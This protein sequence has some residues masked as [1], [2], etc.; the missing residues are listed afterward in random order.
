MRAEFPGWLGGLLAVLVLF[1]F[2]RDLPSTAII[3]LSIP[4]LLYGL[5]GSLRILQ[6]SHQHA[7]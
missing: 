2:L 7:K 3:G 1:F 4:V 6:D 5:F